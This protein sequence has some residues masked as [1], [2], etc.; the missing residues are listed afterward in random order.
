MFPAS[1]EVTSLSLGLREHD[2]CTVLLKPQTTMWEG[3]KTCKVPSNIQM[4][5]LDKT[6]QEQNPPD[7]SHGQATPT[8]F[9]WGSSPL[10]S[11]QGAVAS[12]LEVGT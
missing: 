12:G 11:S 5:R 2:S 9:P 1:S 8:S 6:R 10:S 4:N 7:L 3:C